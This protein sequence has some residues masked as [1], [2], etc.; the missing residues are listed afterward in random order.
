MCTY[1]ALV[2]QMAVR[3]SG[4]VEC[5][6]GGLPVQQKK[7]KHKNKIQQNSNAGLPGRESGRVRRV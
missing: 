6:C 5:E 4:E 2:V 7:M 1:D 3:D